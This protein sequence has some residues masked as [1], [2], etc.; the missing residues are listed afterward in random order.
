ML[1]INKQVAGKMK[2]RVS[3]G[4]EEV[5]GRLPKDAQ[6][7]SVHPFMPV[8]HLLAGSQ[9]SI[10]SSISDSCRVQWTRAPSQT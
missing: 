4:T 8:L 1:K 3:L 5:T 9:I 6:M 10:M 7:P 2:G